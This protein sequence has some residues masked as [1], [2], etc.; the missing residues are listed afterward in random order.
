MLFREGGRGLPNRHGRGGR[1]LLVED[2]VLLREILADELRDEGFDVVEAGT[3]DEAI[4]LLEERLDIDAL[5]TDVRMPG[6]V[7]GIEVAVRARERMPRMPVLVVSGYASELGRRLDVLAPPSAFIPKPF[8]FA[9]ISKAL[10]KLL[11]TA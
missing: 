7:D 9:Q 2:E 3:G 6:K 11:A 4:R 5:C 10:R 1:V 8:R